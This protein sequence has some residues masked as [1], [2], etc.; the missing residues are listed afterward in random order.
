MGETSEHESLS[1][2]VVLWRLDSLDRNVARLVS[3]EAHSALADRVT[4]LESADHAREAWGR[5]VAAGVLL[6][7]VSAAASLVLTLIGG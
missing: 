3:T 7:A 2:G 4:R 5:Q 6:A 1:L